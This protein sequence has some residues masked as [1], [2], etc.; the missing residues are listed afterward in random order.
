MRAKREAS[1]ENI[2]YSS[3]VDVYNDST[4]CDVKE[5][6]Q[7]TKADLKKVQEKKQLASKVL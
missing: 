2:D 5:S 6:I 3:E 7:N 1:K 4:I